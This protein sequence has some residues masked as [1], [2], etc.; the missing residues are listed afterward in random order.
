MW[1]RIF[2]TPHTSEAPELRKAHPWLLGRAEGSARLVE[3]GCLVWKE[4]Y[5]WGQAAAFKFKVVA[6]PY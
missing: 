3:P 5:P 1:K 6:V 2:E 4:I